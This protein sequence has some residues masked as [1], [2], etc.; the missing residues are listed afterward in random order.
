MKFTV[1]VLRQSVFWIR[2]KV[3]TLFVFTSI[4]GLVILGLAG[5][6]YFD[7]VGTTAP[8]SPELGGFAI[9]RNETNVLPYSMTMGLCADPPQ[10]RFDY[11]CMF[12]A[13]GAFNFVFVFP[14]HIKTMF[15]PYKSMVGDSGFQNMTFKEAKWGSAVWCSFFV[16]NDSHSRDQI[17]TIV[18]EFT[19]EKTFQ[20]GSKGSYTIFF[21]FDPVAGG[22]PSSVVDAPFKEF[23]ID[24]FQPLGLRYITLDIFG[25]P[26]GS[27][28]TNAFPQPDRGPI[29]GNCPGSTLGKPSTYVEWTLDTLLNSV[30][31]VIFAPISGESKIYS[32]SLMS[33]VILNYN[34]PQAVDHYST[35]LFISGLFFG[36]GSSLLTTAVYD[37]FK[38]RRE[39]IRKNVE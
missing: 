9:A 20:S 14:F 19:I 28:L 30:N 2:Q 12:N 27:V 15:S 22:I 36:I 6:L 17:F 7:G 37:A 38:E 16:A 32:A 25:L 21:P 35:D 1:V 13:S 10:F 33:S 11:S 34:D 29:L 31:S 4:V 3:L 18:G 39:E 24:S 23:G 8:F 26:D 5:L